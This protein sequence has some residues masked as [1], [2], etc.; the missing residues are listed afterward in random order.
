[1]LRIYG[2]ITA[3]H[4]PWLVVLAGT[5]CLFACFTTASL[6]TRAGV[7]ERSHGLAWLTVAGVVFGSGVWATH[8]VAELAFRPGIP[9]GHDGPLT[10]LS[11][12]VAIALSWLGMIAAIRYRQFLLGGAVVGAAVGAMHYIGMM[13]LRTPAD[14]RWDMP[15]VW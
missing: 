8:F 9:I 5:I 11:I 3:Q 4:D 7:A 1:M 2:C 12:V 14:L 10:V 6:L 13:A 15:Y